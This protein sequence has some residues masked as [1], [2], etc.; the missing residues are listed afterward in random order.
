MRR[1]GLLLLTLLLTGCTVQ[2]EGTPVA[3]GGSDPELAAAVAALPQR[4]IGTA[5]AM[6]LAAGLVPPTNRWFSGLVFP[7][8]PQPVFPLPLSVGLKPG[9][10]TIGVPQV[11][12]ED[13]TVFGSHTP[14]LDVPID[15]TDLQVAA[16]DDLTVT[17]AYLDRGAEVGR[18]VLTRGSPFVHYTA[19]RAQSLTV[20]PQPLRADGTVDIR[21]GTYGVATDGSLRGSV[22][23][24]PAGGA[25]TFYAVPADG[26]PAEFAAAARVAVTGGSVVE[27]VDGDT[28][29]TTL[30]YRTSGGDTIVGAMPG[31]GAAG[32]PSVGS[33]AT[34]YGRMD[35]CRTTSLQL[36]TPALTPSGALDLGRLDAAERTELERAVTADT[37]TLQLTAADTYF[38]GKQLARATNLLTLAEGLDMAPTAQRIRDQLVP[39]LEQWADP[40]GCAERTTH[41]FVYDPTLRGMVGLENSFGSEEFNDHQFHYGYFLYAA[42]ILGRDDPALVERIAPVIDLLA[43][44]IGNARATGEFPRARAFDPYEGHSWASGFSPFGDGNNQESSSESVTAYNGLALWAE[45]RGQPEQRTQAVAMLSRE[46]SSAVRY[47]TQ[48]DLPS[49]FGH[50]IVSIN[51][52]GKRD[53]ATW[54]SAEPSAILGIQL[55]PM[56]PVAGYLG[57]DVDRIRRAVAEA[58]PNGYDVPLGDYVLMYKAMADRDEALRIARTL[59]NDAIDDGNSRAYLLAWILTR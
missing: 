23:D 22:L 16:Y 5:P 51:W 14:A 7:P 24:L 42:G 10:L 20:G 6:R 55:I 43:A 37:A 52:G 4:S 31:Q 11:R 25:A 33:F 41:C 46:A 39:V 48:P 27:Q 54:F 40:T 36:R 56:S 21:G 3:E 49:G 29:A 47:W 9:G 2:I 8:E 13:K 26:D 28:V 18:V 38:G 45:L 19:T 50:E 30:T 35:L 57:G 58:T 1:V 59:P 17:V 44:D 53:Y 34:L 15:G 12:A 32:C